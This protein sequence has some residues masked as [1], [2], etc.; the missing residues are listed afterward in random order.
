VEILRAQQFADQC[1]ITSL[2][3]GALA[4]VKA[5]DPA[6]AT[7]LIVTQAL[8]DPARVQTDFLAVNQSKATGALIERAA[9]ERK[10]VHVWTVNSIDEME[11]AVERGAANLI[12]DRPAEGVALRLQRARMSVPERLALRLRR[13]LVE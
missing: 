4:Q 3:L 11:R 5:L 12:T 2:D 6:L 13:L 7:G 1:V 9:Q 8:G 10:P